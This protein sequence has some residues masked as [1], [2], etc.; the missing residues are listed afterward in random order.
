MNGKS[1][2]RGGGEKM[3]NFK[4]ELLD[5]V[6]PNFCL[7][8]GAEGE[9][10][11]PDCSAKM[12]C[13]PAEICP[14]CKRAERCFCPGSPL[15]GLWALAHYQDYLIAELI[16]KVKYDYLTGLAGAA[17][18]RHLEMFWQQ[19]ADCFSV[20]TVLIPVPLH[21]KRFLER[22]FNQSE[23]IA[24]ELS[25]VSGLK[26]ES[27]LLKRISHNEPQ[28]GLSG[29]RRRENIKGIFEVDY[30]AISSVWG[31]ELLLID[32]VYTTGS[33]L[34]ECAQ[35]LKSAG[36]PKVSGLVWAAD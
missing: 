20:R 23:I 22:G 2:E 28:V 11:C 1:T 14:I 4:N 24:V 10:L 18:S 27:G 9:L 3:M 15:D 26:V 31:R 29:Q 34:S 5:L 8:C 35:T 7:G 19:A 21:H 36:F 32:D 17:L 30:R 16:K 13:R 33:T 6:F 12:V 25:R